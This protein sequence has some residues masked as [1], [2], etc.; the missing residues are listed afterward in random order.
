MPCDRPVITGD[1]S[2]EPPK[3]DNKDNLPSRVF[4]S[5]K[6]RLTRGDNHA[7]YQA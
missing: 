1:R 2:S 4:L 5:L 3:L 7:F 6:Y